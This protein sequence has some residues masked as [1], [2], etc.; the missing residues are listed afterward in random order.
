ML[1]LLRSL[2]FTGPHNKDSDQGIDHKD[3]WMMEKEPSGVHGRRPKGNIKNGLNAKLHVHKPYYIWEMSVG[4]NE[5]FLVSPITS[6][7]TKE[8]TEALK[9]IK[10]IVLS[11]L[12]QL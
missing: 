3:I 8:N 5:S 7:F 2:K 1:I 11:S 6:M 12:V 9:E 4:Q 10:N